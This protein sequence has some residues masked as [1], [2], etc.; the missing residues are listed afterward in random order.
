M[1]AE[2]AYDPFAPTP[3]PAPAMDLQPEPVSEPEAPVSEPD[4]GVSEDVTP[5]AAEPAYD[6]FAL[7]TDP[8]PEA[9][10]ELEDLVAQPEPAAVAR[11]QEVLVESEPVAPTPAAPS[12][13]T[14]DAQTAKPRSVPSVVVTPA[15]YA[16]VTAALETVSNKDRW[17]IVSVVAAVLVT[18]GFI[19]LATLP[20]GE[21]AAIDLN[22]AP[23]SAPG[24]IPETIDAE[25]AGEAAA[26]SVVARTAPVETTPAPT[27]SPVAPAPRPRVVAPA[28][29]AAAE[30]P[31]P[32]PAPTIETAPLVV[33][34]PPPAQPLPTDPEAPIPTQP[35]G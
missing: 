22:A 18:G 28:R 14:N 31:T 17:I 26:P 10:S 20:A 2:P 15:R 23:P 9:A 12:F 29:Q 19:W 27:V 1:V 6:P 7:T 30:T 11:A 24:V 35:Q 5:M 25:P 34:A 16:G 13:A 3:D 8:E 32:A 33:E 4:L 21:P